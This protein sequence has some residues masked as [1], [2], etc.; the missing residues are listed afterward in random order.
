MGTICVWLPKEEK[1]LKG[2]IL[3]TDDVWLPFGF[4]DV[5]KE[6]YLYIVLQHKQHPGI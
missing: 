1:F 6:H 3:K 2:F 4:F 5:T